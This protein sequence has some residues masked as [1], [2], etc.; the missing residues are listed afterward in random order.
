MTDPNDLT[1]SQKRALAIVHDFRPARSSV[2]YGY[3]ATG[4]I[5]ISL[6]RDLIQRQLVR[7]EGTRLVLTGEGQATYAVMIERKQRRHA[8][9]PRRQAETRP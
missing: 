8:P 2:G 3:L 7:V 5:R 6:A 1:A 9:R 4:R